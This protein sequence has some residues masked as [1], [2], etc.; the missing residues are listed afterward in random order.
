MR[1]FD[2]YLVTIDTIYPDSYQREAHFLATADLLQPAA[3][4]VRTGLAGL[5]DRLRN[6]S[7]RRDSRRALLEMSEGQLSDI[8]IT[9]RE[10]REE[11]YRSRFLVR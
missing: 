9:R 4:P 1:K 10:A 5:F 11:A 7:A 8:G 6:W 3:M 2:E